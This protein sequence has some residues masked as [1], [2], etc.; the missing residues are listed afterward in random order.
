[1][2]K[3]WIVVG[4]LCVLVAAA[5]A[6]GVWSLNRLIVGQHD[7]IIEQAQA[8][9]G[10]P[11]GVAR[12]SVSLW[13]GLGVRLEDVRIA[14]DPRFGSDDFVRVAAISA[15]P[16]IW[17]LLHQR[18]EVSRI[19]ATQPQVTLIRN[20][21]GE[22]N[23]AT[24]RPLAPKHT[25]AP[26]AGILRVADT[27]AAAVPKPAT[28]LA[29]RDVSIADGTFVMVDHT[30]TPVRTTRVAQ[31]DAALRFGAPTA[32][33]EVRIAAAVAADTRN[34]DVRGTIGPWNDPAGVPVQLEGTLGPL[35]P[36]TAR[37]D[38]LHVVAV[39]TRAQVQV[40][41]L[42]GRALGGVFTLSGQYPLQA[43]A[44]AAVRGTVRDLNL[45]E[46]FTAA[47]PGQASR[48]GGKAHLVIDLSGSGTTRAALQDSL[49]GR[50][51]ADIHNGV[52]TQLNVADEV[53]GKASRLPVVGTVVS[54]KIK[55]KYPHLFADPDTHFETLHS[56]FTIG[57]R[58]AQTDDLTVTTA[59]YGILGR[60]WIGV[61]GHVDLAGR[62]RMSK[63]FSDDVVADIHAAKYLLDDDA[64]LALPFH[65]RGELR[66]VKATLD[67][68]DIMA[69]VQRG[70]ARGGAK[71][72]LDKFLGTQPQETP[73][74]GK[75]PIGE[76][77]RRL[78]RH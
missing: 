13:G 25:A 20:A 35:A 30:Q 45:A 32:P 47:Y 21:D 52:I 14:D 70:A 54:E 56:T 55:P 28:R 17:P 58:R 59:E 53:L 66:K 31:L 43:D 24:L 40:K 46:A 64:Q 78:F 15:H 10:R 18:F 44:E 57:E 16:K 33:V 34:I 39:L 50:I 26:A 51:V 49:A 42:T 3:L 41:E 77:L 29:V 76:G 65:L 9:L 73:G 38:G 71:D 68:D 69:L 48:L 4:A 2:R 5:V 63:R 27:T 37:I 67:R 1:M 61:D 72:L 22:W 36:S 11:V 8:V 62:L 23:Y 74:E 7:R 12:I 19:V 75:D 60:G 6:T